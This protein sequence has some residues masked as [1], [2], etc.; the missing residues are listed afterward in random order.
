[1]TISTSSQASAG[2]LS[3]FGSASGMRSSTT[4][5][6]VYSGRWVENEEERTK[7]IDACKLF[8]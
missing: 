4:T 2:S 5:G 6:A 7:I 1:M 8:A 3:L